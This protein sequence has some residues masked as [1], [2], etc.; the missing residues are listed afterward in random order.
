MSEDI[1]GLI[2]QVQIRDSEIQSLKQQ[3]AEA[4]EA[5]K[6]Y[7]ERKHLE[8][9]EDANQT[10]INFGSNHREWKIGPPYLKG[11]EYGQKAREALK[12]IGEIK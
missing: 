12:K 8:L 6:F 2:N 3:L 7:S 10:T 1:K 11:A 5:L 9:S 4:V